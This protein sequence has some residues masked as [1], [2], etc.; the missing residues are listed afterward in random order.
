MNKKNTGYKNFCLRENLNSL[1]MFQLALSEA[2]L[3][4]STVPTGPHEISRNASSRTYIGDS[5]RILQLESGTPRNLI[6]WPKCVIFK[7]G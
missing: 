5:P 4:A 1:V 2:E 6:R 3:R 7:S